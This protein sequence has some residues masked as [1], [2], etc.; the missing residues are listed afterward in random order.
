M[1]ELFC[2]ASDTVGAVLLGNHVVGVVACLDLH[3]GVASDVDNIF[4]SLACIL[5]H[6]HSHHQVERCV[7]LRLAVLNAGDFSIA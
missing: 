4:E 3:F 7:D 5:T 2:E 1:T 6:S